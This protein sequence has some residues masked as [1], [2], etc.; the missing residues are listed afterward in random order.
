MAAGS[1]WSVAGG[2]G[3][4][5]A[6]RL[7]DLFCG[8]GG[9]AM[10]YHQAGFT[11]IVGVDIEPQPN[12]PF[13]FVQGD[14]LQ[15]PVRLED[16][17]LIHASPPCQAYSITAKAFP[18][19][20]KR[21]YPMLVEPIQEMLADHSHVI[22]NVPGAPLRADVI[23]C[24]S[25]FG[26]SAFDPDMDRTMHLRR[27]RLFQTSFPLMAPPDMCRQHAGSIAGVY[28]GGGLERADALA[29]R[30]RRGGYTPKA[31]VRRALME[32]PWASMKECN[33]AIPPAYTKFIGEAFISQKVPA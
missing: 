25:M 13:E 27:H 12:Y 3:R 18:H 17:D 21:R 28:G 31:D 1:V 16:F 26:L 29:G 15:P 19:L 5:L 32:M 9:A 33:E 30:T 11:E 23:L 24:G 4:R 8:A 10:G 14:V 7:L 2:V 6:V 22:E 20:R